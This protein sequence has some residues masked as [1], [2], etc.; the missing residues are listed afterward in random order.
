[1]AIASIRE[2][3]RSDEA[4]LAYAETEQLHRGDSTLEVVLLGAESLD[5]LKIT[6]SNYFGGSHHELFAGVLN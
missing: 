6:H 4:V 5:D 1:M 3:R 2:F